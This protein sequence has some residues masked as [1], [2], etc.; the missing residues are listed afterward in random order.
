MQ[1]WYTKYGDRVEIVAVDDLINGDY[2]AALKG[3]SK[4][5]MFAVYVTHRLY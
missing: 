3:V 5:Y 1:E 4:T 2:S